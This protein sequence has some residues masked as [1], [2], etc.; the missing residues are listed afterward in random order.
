MTLTIGPQKEKPRTRS[1]ASSARSRSVSASDGRRDRR[2]ELVVQPNPNDLLVHVVLAAERRRP[3]DQEGRDTRCAAYGRLIGAEL[4]VHVAEIDVQVFEL[5]GPAVSAAEA[6]ELSDRGLNAATQGPSHLDG[7]EIWRLPAARQAECAKEPGPLG[8]EA[9]RSPV[10]PGED[11]SV[12]LFSILAQAAPPVTYQRL[13]PCAQ[14]RRPRA[15]LTQSSLC[16]L[17]Q[18]W[19]LAGIK[20]K[21]GSG[22]NIP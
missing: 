22:G 19:A 2:I 21:L 9:S 11:T 5:H 12:Y 14:P 8:P 3:G 6:Q 18:P 7:A 15:V 17:V 4:I 13:V 16:S 10:L 20:K 1:G